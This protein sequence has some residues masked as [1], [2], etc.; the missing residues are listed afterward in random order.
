MRI[1]IRHTSRILV[2]I[3][4]GSR[5]TAADYAEP[6]GLET[7]IPSTLDAQFP[8]RSKEKNRIKIR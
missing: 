5:H 4:M 6:A 2:R 8:C 1:D 3:A 7:F